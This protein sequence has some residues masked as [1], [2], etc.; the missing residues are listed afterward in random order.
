MCMCFCVLHMNP[1]VVPCQDVSRCSRH[2]DH[3]CSC[4]H[5]SHGNCF[6]A[7]KSVHQRLTDFKKSICYIQAFTYS[8]QLNIVTHLVT[9]L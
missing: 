7:L 6:A 1:P 3:A 5:G 2:F 4:T 8:I 9:S